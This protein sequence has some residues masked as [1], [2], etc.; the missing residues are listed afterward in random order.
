MATT[1]IVV[2]TPSELKFMAQMEGRHEQ[3]FPV[4]SITPEMTQAYRTLR[5]YINR[6]PG[7]I[8]LV[9]LPTHIR[10][11]HISLP[12]VGNLAV[13]ATWQRAPQPA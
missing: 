7:S 13:T 11:F 6:H 10:V 4:D 3:S 9:A 1:T 2:M 5:A 8:Q 12:R